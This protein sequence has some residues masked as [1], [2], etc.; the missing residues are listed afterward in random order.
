MLLA[1]KLNVSYPEYSLFEI[2]CKFDI[3]VILYGYESIIVLSYDKLP[4]CG[5]VVIVYV[6]S[7]SLPVKNISTSL[8]GVILIYCELA[9]G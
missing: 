8:L 2:Y 1:V 3:P 4:C 7:L 9:I 5:N 6:K